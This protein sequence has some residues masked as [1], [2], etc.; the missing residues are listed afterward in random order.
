PAAYEFLDFVA[1]AKQGLWQV[2]PLNPPAN[3]NSPYSSTS[4]FAGNPLLISLERLAQER[5]LDSSDLSAL[6]RDVGPIDYERVNRE[7]L[8]VIQRA[9]G[10]FLSRAGSGERERFDYFCA[11]NEWWLEDFVLFDL[12][13]ERHG[14]DWSK[15][16]S[17][18]ARRDPAML[19]DLRQST[20]SDLAMRR[21]IQFFFWEQ[22][23][24]LRQYCAQKSIKVV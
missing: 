5:W 21:V 3:G 13:R 2:L 11:E 22:W 12:L 6:T 20:H 7:K 23:R 10:N 19:H 16:P 8:P 9:A 1:E 4:A 15:W 24:A 14:G 17:Q 18:L